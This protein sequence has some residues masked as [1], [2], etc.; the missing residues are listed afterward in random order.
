[1][2]KRFVDFMRYNCEKWMTI[3][4]Y[5]YAAYYRICLLVLKMTQME[6]KMGIRGEESVSEES[7]ETLRLA[8]L[9][10]FHVNRVTQ[11]LPLKRKCWVRAL[12]ARKI[13]LKH[14]ICSTLYM[15]VGKENG[16]MVAHAWLRCGQLFVT[17]G[18]GEGY[19]TVAKFKAF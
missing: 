18:N 1:M 3:T 4:V 14:G 15:G 6:K 7:I 12:T 10:S 17:G 13:L 8:R 2:I 19:A 16:N 5:I 11:H 9:V